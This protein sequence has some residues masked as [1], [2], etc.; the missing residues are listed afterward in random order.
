MPAVTT[1]T[2]DSRKGFERGTKIRIVQ[3]LGEHGYESE[4]QIAIHDLGDPLMQYDDSGYPAPA[5][6]K[7][8][9]GFYFICI[10]IVNYIHT[11]HSP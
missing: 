11:L 4:K 6:V 2:F 1:R 8:H 3:P 10:Y 7:I 9:F 5:T